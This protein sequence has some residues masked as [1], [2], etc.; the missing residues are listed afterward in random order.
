[1][2]KI[3]KIILLG[4][5]FVFLVNTCSVK[6]NS[7]EDLIPKMND[8]ILQELLIQ[9]INIMNEGIYNCDDI[10]TVINKL[11][12]IEEGSILK[13]DITFLENISQ[14]PTDYP[15]VNNVKVIDIIEMKYEEGVYSVVS[16]L[17]WKISY[18][19]SD[20]IEEYEYV[21]QLRYKDNKFLLTDF[22]LHV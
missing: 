14:N 3:I 5:F 11:K 10:N 2:K 19:M 4:F 21:I 17:E 12:N 13:E 8:E 22:K 1:M 18:N 7:E 9:K 6:A 20:E 15:K 16:K